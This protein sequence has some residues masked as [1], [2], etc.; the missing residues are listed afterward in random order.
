[1]IG[2][3]HGCTFLRLNY[4]EHMMVI[5]N[6]GAKKDHP[7]LVFCHDRETQDLLKETFG[8]FDVF[9]PQYKVSYPSDSKRHNLPSDS[10]TNSQSLYSIKAGGIVA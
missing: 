7:A 4:G 5:F 6:I 9:D 2:S 3:G 8:V 1:M 10:I